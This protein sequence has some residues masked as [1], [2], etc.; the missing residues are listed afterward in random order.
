MAALLQLLPHLSAESAAMALTLCSG[1]SVEAAAAWALEHAE[2]LG[3]AVAAAAAK[4]SAAADITGLRQEFGAHMEQNET[5]WA[6]RLRSKDDELNRLRANL[7]SVGE[8]LKAEVDKAKEL[9]GELAL[10]RADQRRTARSKFS[11][12]PA[13]RD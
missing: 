13:E 10:L 1:G 8:V 6:A 4:R 7:A 2:A 11:P 12:A 9:E 5:D 3:A